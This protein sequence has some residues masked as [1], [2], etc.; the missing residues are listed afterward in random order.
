MLE[1][2]NVCDANTTMN[3][4]WKPSTMKIRSFDRDINNAEDIVSVLNYEIS[5]Y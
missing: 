4:V 3:V 5:L 2:D 1:L